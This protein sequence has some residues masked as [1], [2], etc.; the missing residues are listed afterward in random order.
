MLLATET[1]RLPGASSS[2]KDIFVATR[3][4]YQVPS[5]NPLQV[6]GLESSVTRVRRPFQG[7]DG[8]PTP[9][10]ESHR[11]TLSRSMSARH[12]LFGDVE[13]A[14]AVSPRRS[15]S[16]V[17]PHFD[18]T[19][20]TQLLSPPRRSKSPVKPPG[21]ALPWQR[22][23]GVTA[24]FRNDP[25][26]LPRTGVKKFLAERAALCEVYSWSPGK[27]RSAKSPTR[28]LE[29]G[30]ASPP[31]V[32]SQTHRKNTSSGPLATGLTEKS[33]ADCLNVALGTPQKGRKT[34][35]AEAAAMGP[36]PSWAL[37]GDILARHHSAPNSKW[38]VPVVEDVSEQVLTRGMGRRK[39]SPHSQR[40]RNP[41]TDTRVDW[42]KVRLARHEAK[43]NES[44]RRDG[45][46]FRMSSLPQVSKIGWCSEKSG[47]L[48]RNVVR[49]DSPSSTRK[50]EAELLLQDTP[51]GL[52]AS[53]NGTTHASEASRRKSSPYPETKRPFHSPQW[54]QS[55]SLGHPGSPVPDER[56]ARLIEHLREP[57]LNGRTYLPNSQD[58]TRDHD[59][60]RLFGSASDGNLLQS[61]RS[62]EATQGS[63]GKDSSRLLARRQRS[64]P[65]K[66]FPTT[67][68]V[69]ERSPGS[70][71]AKPVSTKDKPRQRAGLDDTFAFESAAKTSFSASTRTDVAPTPVDVKRS[72]DLAVASAT[73]LRLGDTSDGHLG[74]NVSPSVKS[75]VSEAS[76]GSTRANGSPAATSPASPSS[77]VVDS[78]AA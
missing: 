70:T 57:R 49:K 14:P 8:S 4:H 37:H 18:S 27:R 28:S 29:D 26:E 55:A 40:S 72:V 60:P 67:D 1:D 68:S 61:I 65:D 20:L 32:S 62:E 50:K 5:T 25:P 45:A 41:I 11:S 69:S 46:A 24:Y 2:R 74:L 43:D 66:K 30:S 44:P 77:P 56:S 17:P 23:S 64:R 33:V 34:L 38:E 6:G 59:A 63:R 21:E 16:P 58:V 78:T 53:D 42:E 9:S 19:A 22:S 7:L 75:F 54:K 31:V 47:D 73:K 36:V 35:G 3:R 15:T 13:R 51:V 12:R 39:R 52:Q 10:V 48:H 76:L 71:E